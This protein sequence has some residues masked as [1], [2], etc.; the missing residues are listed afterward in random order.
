LKG[1]FVVIFQATNSSESTTF[2][3]GCR[4]HIRGK[5]RIPR[6][7]SRGGGADY[8]LKQIVSKR[9]RRSMIS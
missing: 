6:S 7:S 5:K 2:A 1:A 9:E 8:H 4:Q 3:D